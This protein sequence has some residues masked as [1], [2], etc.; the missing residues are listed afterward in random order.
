MARKSW[1]LQVRPFKFASSRGSAWAE[2]KFQTASVD[3]CLSREGY[4]YMYCVVSQPKYLSFW[5]PALNYTD[6]DSLER[7]ITYSLALV[8]WVGLR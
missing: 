6:Y 5:N 7:K 4:V 2:I 8:V 3:K 1:H